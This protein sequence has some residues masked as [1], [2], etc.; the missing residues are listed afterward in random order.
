MPEGLSKAESFESLKQDLQLLLSQFNLSRYQSELY[1]ELLLRGS[2]TVAGLSSHTSVPRPKIY[3]N[4]DSLYVKG[5]VQSTGDN[6]KTYSATDLLATAEDYSRE[7]QD[8]ALELQARAAELCQRLLA[9]Q[10]EQ[11]NGES[12]IVHCSGKAELLKKFASHLRQAK[13]Y[14]LISMPD[15]SIIPELFRELKKTVSRGVN[16]RVFGSREFSR[17]AE[18][19]HEAGCEVRLSGEFLPEFAFSDDAMLMRGSEDYRSLLRVSPSRVS[20]SFKSLF[21]TAWESRSL[22]FVGEGE[23][24]GVPV[25]LV[26]EDWEGKYLVDLWSSP[27]HILTQ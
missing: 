5:L 27:G 22:P 20:E 18:A 11:G 16:V 2:L 8:K 13:N 24:L 15:F 10:R 26:R 6:P 4:L 14:V 21:F 17:G 12:W 1:S 25:A 7:F 19:F 9:L 23:P 3:E